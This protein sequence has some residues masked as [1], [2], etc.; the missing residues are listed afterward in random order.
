[1]APVKLARNVTAG[2]ATL[3]IE[4]TTKNVKLENTFKKLVLQ[5][6]HIVF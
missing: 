3:G 2:A 4:A 5:K 1:L 6:I